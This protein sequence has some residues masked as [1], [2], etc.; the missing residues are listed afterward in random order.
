LPNNALHLI[1][2]YIS[3]PHTDKLKKTKK[4]KAYI[5]LERNADDLKKNERN[6]DKLKIITKKRFM[7]HYGRHF[8]FGGEKDK[9]KL[10]DMLD[11]LDDS[12]STEKE[13]LERGY[14]P[15]RYFLNRSFKKYKQNVY[16]YCQYL[17]SNFDISWEN[18]NLIYTINSHSNIFK[19]IKS[20]HKELTFEEFY[21]YFSYYYNRIRNILTYDKQLNNRRL[22]INE[23][24]FKKAIKISF[25]KKDS[26]ENLL[27]KD[28]IEL[29]SCIFKN[30][31]KNDL[32]KYKKDELEAM[33]NNYM[34]SKYEFKPELLKMISPNVDVPITG[35][36]NTSKKYKIIE[37]IVEN[38]NIGAPVKKIRKIKRS[39]IG[40]YE[41]F[42]S[43]NIIE[44][45]FEF[46]DNI[47][48]PD[49][50]VFKAHI[51]GIRL[52]KRNPIT[53]IRCN[54]YFGRYEKFLK[55]YG[56]SPHMVEYAL[57]LNDF[58][59]NLYYKKKDNKLWYDYIGINGKEFNKKVIHHTY[60]IRVNFPVNFVN[61]QTSRDD[62]LIS[63][64]IS[65]IIR[66]FV[67]SRIYV[68]NNVVSPE[69]S[70]VSSALIEVKNKIY[71]YKKE[72]EGIVKNKDKRW[73]T[74]KIKKELV[75]EGQ[76]ADNEEK[77]L[78]IRERYA[79]YNNA[80]Y[81]EEYFLKNKT[82]LEEVRQQ[83][84]KE[85]KER[86][87][88]EKKEREL[89]E[90]RQ[91]ELKYIEAVQ[92]ARIRLEKRQQELKYIEAVQLA[93]IRLE[94][95]QQELKEKRHVKVVKISKEKYD[96]K[97]ERQYKAMLLLVKHFYKKDL[98]R[99]KRDLLKDKIIII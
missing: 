82:K 76:I 23:L 83:K 75:L 32:R 49:N 99:M 2:R 68:R 33:V 81:I 88:K 86:E 7:K 17:F 43:G 71:N 59:K 16:L 9:K 20:K 21:Y 24:N 72:L 4:P 46:K 69:Y 45:S 90:K 80:K 40:G 10:I 78:K 30:Q 77:L 42:K 52:F 53:H 95:R 5:F 87:L 84:L 54:T 31:S 27:K 91:Q 26:G 3:S 96:D 89:K 29:S 47:V 35:L 63:N 67:K 39:C 79:V 97:T 25:T 36:K 94:K 44:L 62:R 1:G 61:V 8:L 22:L 38:T 70:S 74:R 56:Y 98:N 14:Y 66:G 92:L 73:K 51:D 11:N 19:R 60:N 15:N 48:L 50:I 93:R 34:V 37:P 28:Y 6:F 64:Y 55:K 57:V 85:K 41:N 18:P 58:F 12:L 13:R 65:G